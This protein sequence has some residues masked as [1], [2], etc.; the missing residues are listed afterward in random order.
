VHRLAGCLSSLP[1]HL[2]LVLEL[3]TG[4]GGRR[5]LEPAALAR[6]LHLTASRLRHLQR[7]ALLVL[8]RT[9]RTH[10]CAAGSTSA[11]D[12]IR[13][14]GGL[15][16]SEGGGPAALGGVE[17][18]RYSKPASPGRGTPAGTQAPGT[19]SSLGVSR[20]PGGGNALLAVGV[21]ILGMLSIALL[22]AEELGLGPYIRRLRARWLRR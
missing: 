22:F 16:A 6:R 2:R 7:H 21:I 14:E 17:A 8:V 12:L 1:K 3:S 10:A 15:A 18:A 19:A 20:T 11:A 13:L 5:A 9:A 4:I